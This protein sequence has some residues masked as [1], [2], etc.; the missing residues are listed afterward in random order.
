[1]RVRGPAIAADGS[2]D[3]TTNRLGEA[4][5][6]GSTTVSEPRAA[7]IEPVGGRASVPDDAVESGVS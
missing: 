4:S 2:A 6:G 3:T 7:T 1:M 5:N